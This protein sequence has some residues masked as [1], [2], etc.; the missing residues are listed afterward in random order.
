MLLYWLC[1]VCAGNFLA[2]VPMRTFATV[3]DMGIIQKA[4]N[5][6]PWAVLLVLGLPFAI[7]LWFLFSRML[8]NLVANV[9]TGMFERTLVVVLTPFF[10]FVFY[11]S[12]GWEPAF[13]AVCKTLAVISMA[14]IF[15]LLSVILW[16]R[17]AK[18]RAASLEST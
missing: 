15:P 4:L 11:G 6:S 3:Y 8:P 14:L 1:V 13:N 18:P 7:G 17:L 10:I 16:I 2:Y 9:L 5:V 12:A